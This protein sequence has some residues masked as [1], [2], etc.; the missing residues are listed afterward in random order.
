MPSP[1]PEQQSGAESSSGGQPKVY[2][3]VP[4]TRLDSSASGGSGPPSASISSANSSATNLHITLDEPHQEQQQQPQQRRVDWA[5]PAAQDQDTDDDDD[6]RDEELA[7]EHH[8]SAQSNTAIASSLAKLDGHHSNKSTQRVSVQSMPESTTPR[9]ASLTPELLEKTLQKRR[10]SGD[11]SR[12]SDRFYGP[13]AAAAAAAASRGTSMDGG[14]PRAARHPSL[15]HQVSRPFGFSLP[16]GAFQ[17]LTSIDLAAATA[18]PRPASFVTTHSR[19]SHTLSHSQI[20]HTS[21]RSNSQRQSHYI[22]PHPLER[23]LS[24]ASRRSSALLAAPRP[25]SSVANALSRRRKSTR[26]ASEKDQQEAAAQGAE[27]LDDAKDDDD[28]HHARASW[29]D[30]EEEEDEDDA[31]SRDFVTAASMQAGEAEDADNTPGEV[32]LKSKA[33]TNAVRESHGT[34]KGE[35]VFFEDAER[36]CVYVNRAFSPSSSMPPVESGL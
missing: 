11:W 30:A 29:S 20:S 13:N 16:P 18:T 4:M 26:R 19:H 35:T 12:L 6:D 34:E 23:S 9:Q 22:R 5:E 10:A 25:A 15:R 14:R 8:L 28:D 1:R 33:K 36:V 3:D 24:A 2:L 32:W 31:T 7:D 21:R 27:E 17:G